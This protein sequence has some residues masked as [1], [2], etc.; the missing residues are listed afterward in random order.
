MRGSIESKR[1]FPP[2]FQKAP[3]TCLLHIWR[4]SRAQCRVIALKVISEK[5][6]LT[7]AWQ[8]KCSH[9]QRERVEIG[10][11]GKKYHLY[12]LLEF[13]QLRDVVLEL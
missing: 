5:S 6:S 8:L 9:P 12:I 2:T 10:R 1:H 13:L 4:G 11:K 7:A 3:P